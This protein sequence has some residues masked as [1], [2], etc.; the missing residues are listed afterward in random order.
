MVDIGSAISGTFNQATLA[1]RRA[2]ADK[3]RAHAAEEERLREARKRFV[4]TQEEVAQ[5]ETLRG[6]RVEPDKERSEGQEARDQYE[7]HRELNKRRPPPR[8][9]QPSDN[10]PGPPAETDKPPDSET[11]HIIDLEA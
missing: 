2:E 1:S 8:L 11:G 7:A 5:T 9:E 3:A 6:M 10:P 4:A